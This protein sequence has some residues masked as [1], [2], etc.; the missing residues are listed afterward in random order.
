MV[1]SKWDGEKKEWSIV[2]DRYQDGKVTR[3]K[4][5]FFKGIVYAYLY[6]GTLHPHHIIQATGL[7]GEPQ[8]PDIPGIETF[9]GPIIH[10]TQFTDGSSFANKK[11][12]VVGTG[13]SGH[14]ISQGL[15]RHGATVTIVQRSPTFVMSLASVHQLVRKTFNEAAILEDVDIKTMSNPSTLFKRIGSDGSKLVF[16]PANRQL[17][18]DLEAV[19]FRTISDEEGDLPSL[20]PLTIARA[21]GFYI[22]IG[23]SSLIASGQ[24]AVKSSPSITRLTRTGMV[25]A[26]GEEISADAI[27]F[28]T[29]YSNGRVRTRK[30]FGDEVADRISPVFG[31]DAQ[32]EIRGAWRRSGQEG[33]WVAAGAFWISRYYS[34]L[35][36]LQIKMIEEGLVAV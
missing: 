11:V 29:G 32:G 12:I 1:G 9:E 22:D 13:T 30:V 10:S 16:A 6:Q 18:R 34:R 21:G 17:W 19:G 36:A 23:C 15:H 27:V 2:L 28:A 8:I 3:S 24:I 20:L 33:F 5:L 7:N 25:F 35:L 4:S 14:D 31:F 26:D